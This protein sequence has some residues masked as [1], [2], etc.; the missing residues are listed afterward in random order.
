MR[1][2]AEKT[3]NRGRWVVYKTRGGAHEKFIVQDL[4]AAVGMGE[5]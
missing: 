3:A 2:I 1:L 5:A 4:P